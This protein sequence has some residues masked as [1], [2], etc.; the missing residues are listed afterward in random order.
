MLWSAKARAHKHD[1]PF[2]L[3]EDD[4]SI[5]DKCPVLGFNL[6]SQYGKGRLAYNSPT[7]DRIRPELG[8]TKG[9]VI[10]VSHRAN[11]I[12]SDA[13]PYEIKKVAEFFS[14]MYTYKV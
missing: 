6:E 2:N 10:V 8:Y 9:N 14:K 3:T 4:I 13:T 5:P 7:L 1:I 12:K 11:R